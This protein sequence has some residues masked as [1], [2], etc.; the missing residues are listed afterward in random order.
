MQYGKHA[1]FKLGP[2]PWKKELLFIEHASCLAFTY[3]QEIRA[4]THLF[5]APT[6]LPEHDDSSCKGARLK[7]RPIA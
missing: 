6:K 7:V 4:S 5:P 1:M 3:F 2:R